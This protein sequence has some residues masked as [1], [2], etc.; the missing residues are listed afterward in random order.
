MQVGNRVPDYGGVCRQQMDRVP[1]IPFDGVSQTGLF[2]TVRRNP[3]NGWEDAVEYARDKIVRGLACERGLD[4]A[5]ALVPED[6]DE[7][8]R[9]QMIQRVLDAADGLCASPDRRGCAR[10]G[11]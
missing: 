10:S 9:L 3:A 2:R 1:N 4:G 8:W 6:E 5:A 7:L 11:R